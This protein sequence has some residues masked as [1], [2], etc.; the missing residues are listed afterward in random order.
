MRTRTFRLGAGFRLFA[1]TAGL[2]VG[3]GVLLPAAAPAAPAAVTCTPPPVYPI[4]QLQPGMTAYGLTVIQGTEP[5]RFDVTIIGVQPDGLGL[6][7]DAI[8]V[9]G[10]S[11][12]Q[13]F[14]GFPMG[15][16]GSPVYIGDRLVGAVSAIA[17][18]DP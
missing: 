1:L 9:Q 14:G 4:D 8:V 17:W 16:S 15:V 11:L 18:S 3:G 6:G 13:Q 12:I 10:G 7:V 2:V 5:T